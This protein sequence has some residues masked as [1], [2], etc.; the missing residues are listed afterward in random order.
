MSTATQGEDWRWDKADVFK[1]YPGRLGRPECNEWERESYDET[2]DITGD[3]T[4]RRTWAL[5]LSEME[6]L[7]KLEQ[8]KK[9]KEKKTWAEEQNDVN[10][11]ESCTLL[12][13]D[14]GLGSKDRSQ[15]IG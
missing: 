14:R 5:I 13:E 7:R 11:F 1:E 9:R 10:C 15:E 2:G 8:K 3:Q 6:I 4:H 12:L